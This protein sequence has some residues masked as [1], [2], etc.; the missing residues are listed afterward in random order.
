MQFDYTHNRQVSWFR[1]TV[2]EIVSE[3]PMKKKVIVFL[4]LSVFTG[5]VYS[6]FDAQLSQYMLHNSSFNPA[7]VGESGMI[8]IIGQHRINWLN[9]AGGGSTTAFS[10]STPVKI[11]NTVHGLGL[12]FLDDQFGGF[13]NKAFHLQYAYKKNIGPGKLSV[14]TD[15]G[16]VSIGFSGDSVALHAIN[17]GEYH[18]MTSD[19]AIPLTNVNGMGL[20]LNVGIWYSMSNWYAGASYLHLNQPKVK[21]GNSTEFAL[22]SSLFLTGGLSYKLQDPKYVLKPSALFKSDF[23]TWQLDLSTRLEYDNRFWGGLSYRYQDAVVFM[24]GLNIAGG[25][26]L[27][28]SFD[29]STS[30][31]ITTNY[32]SHEFVLIYSFEYVFSKSSSKYKSI[33]FM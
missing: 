23:S 33:R 26:S 24:G 25:L 22:Y 31:L 10:I 13:T 12:S 17:I 27:G 9:F 3:N 30:K 28:Y 20:N 7:A 21:W 5:S 29:L 32:G 1:W 19:P 11:E 15:I 4:F 14:G 2:N 16:F 6:Q 18:N 8:D